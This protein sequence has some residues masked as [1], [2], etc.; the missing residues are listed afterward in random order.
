MWRGSAT[1][2]GAMAFFSPGITNMVYVYD[3]SSQEWSELPH[4]RHHAFTLIAVDNLLTTVGGSQQK[5]T[6]GN[7]LL[8]FSRGEWTELFPPMSTERSFP[9]VVCAGHSLVVAGGC[10]QNAPTVEIMNT[11]TLQWFTAASLPSRKGIL[12]SNSASMTACGD[13]VYIFGD[14]RTHVYSSS[15]LAL[16]ESC[17]DG[18]ETTSFQQTSTHIWNRI[19]D[20]PVSRSTAV[21]LCDQLISVGGYDDSGKVD[22][23]Y[24]YDPATN[25]WKKM[26]K[27]LSPKGLPL[28]TTLPGDKLI[29]VHGNHEKSFIGTAIIIEH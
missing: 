29:V 24:Y 11:D 12:A 15:L 25:I 26:G 17:Q 18:K 3:S 27:L 19:S 10:S 2:V 7:T 16:L 1:S 4:C 8:S 22:F 21:T 23:V 20:L 9:A 5:Y 14:D 6:S 28:A 13:S